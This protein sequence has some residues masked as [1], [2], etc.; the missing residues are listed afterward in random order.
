MKLYDLSLIE[1]MGKKDFDFVREVVGMFLE[2]IPVDIKQ[3]N[4]A[5]VNKDAKLFGHVAHKLKSTID[6]LGILS[7]S[8]TIRQVEAT[9]ILDF[10]SD[11][12][13]QQEVNKIT[14]VLTQV[15]SE[16]NEK[17]SNGN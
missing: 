1:A 14:S 3:L 7:V 15:Y 2:S 17:Y 4:E 12:T 6:T 10:A 5:F 9:D 8:E 13:L 11:Q 16:L